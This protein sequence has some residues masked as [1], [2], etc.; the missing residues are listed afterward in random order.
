MGKR[1][2]IFSH[3]RNQFHESIIVNQGTACI[4]T[5]TNIYVYEYICVCVHVCVSKQN[6]L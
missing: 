1:N 4:Y 5:Y 2:R 3:P 6:R